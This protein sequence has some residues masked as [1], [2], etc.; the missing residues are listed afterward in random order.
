M[1]T[2][3]EYYEQCLAENPEQVETVNGVEIPLTE[4]ESCQ[5]CAAWAQMKVDQDN[6]EPLGQ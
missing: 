6:A 5:A 1:T 3:D 2:Y 4:E